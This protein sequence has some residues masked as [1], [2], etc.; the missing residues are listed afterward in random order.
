M[1]NV[2]TGNPWILDTAATLSTNNIL[3]DKMVF[4]PNAAD[5]DLIVKD[6]AGKVIWQIRAITA[7]NNYQSSGMETFDG[8]FL[9]NGF[10]LDTI[11]AGTLKV[12]L[13]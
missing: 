7:S 3:V 1:A 12:Y 10:V 8:P 5:N 9:C 2:A 4:I 6:N 11:D 13:R